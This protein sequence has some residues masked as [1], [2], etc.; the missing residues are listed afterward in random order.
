MGREGWIALGAGL[1]ALIAVVVAFRGS[2]FKFWRDIAPVVGTGAQWVGALGSLATMGVALYGISEAMP[3]FQN[4]L[5]SER[6]AELELEIRSRTAATEALVARGIE[7]QAH[8]D[9]MTQK[10]QGLTA[11]VRTA[12][13][14]FVCAKIRS[15]L[16]KKYSRY[17]RSRPTVRWKDVMEA[18]SSSEFL[19]LLAEEDAGRIRRRFAVLTD[20]IIVREGDTFTKAGPADRRVLS[21]IFGVWPEGPLVEEECREARQDPL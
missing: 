7:L 18:A 3:L 14:S 12:S 13:F 4:R 9:E 11:D 21:A 19:N 1:V 2:I 20:K 15:D 5:L 17:L 6:N 10:L 16:E 8:V